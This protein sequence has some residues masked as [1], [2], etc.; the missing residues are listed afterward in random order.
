M[1][2]GDL[3][4]KAQILSLAFYTCYN[5]TMKTLNKMFVNNLVLP[6]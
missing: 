5:K 6:F 1:F 2:S 4:I 3:R